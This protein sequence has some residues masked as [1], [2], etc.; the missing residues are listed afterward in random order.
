MPAIIRIRHPRRKAGKECKALVI[1][2]A[3][4]WTLPATRL[5]AGI[6]DPEPFTGSN[7][8]GRAN[9]KG[10]LMLVPIP[11]VLEGGVA[12][13]SS[14]GR[15]AGNQWRNLMHGWKLHAAAALAA[16]I[17]T[18]PAASQDIEL[19][20]VQDGRDLMEVCTRAEG[21]DG[22]AGAFCYGF[23]TG[24]GSMYATVVTA[25][26]VPRMVCPPDSANI[27]L[28]AIRQNFLD[29]AEDNP[30]KLGN[31]AADTLMEAS[32]RRWPCPSTATR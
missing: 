26:A 24:T 30:G 16:T 20:K 19:F 21:G 9:S 2:F 12:T 17:S 32:A 22:Q 25:N 6:G 4:A 18:G 29:W 5:A 1:H 23:I 11:C 14:I 10:L 7:I 3:L 28:S 27:S 15:P 13:A 8:E 31:P